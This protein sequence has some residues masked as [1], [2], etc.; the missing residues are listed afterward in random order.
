MRWIEKGPRPGCLTALARQA[1]R[2]ERETGTPPTANDWDPGTCAQTIRD[3]LHS[4]QH[5]LCGYCTQRILAIGHLD[6]PPPNGNGGMRIEHLLPR[7]P[8]TGDPRRM[9]DWENLLGVCGGRS[10]APGGAVHDHCDRTRG[11]QPLTLD[12][13]RAPHVE[14]VLWF[15]REPPD[16]ED[17]DGLW[18]HGPEDLAVDVATLNLN[19]PVLRGRR[20]TVENEIAL[21][22]RRLSARGRSVRTWL[23]RLL[24]TATTPDAAGLLPPFAPVV[25]QY[26]ERKLRGL[27]R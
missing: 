1:R 20:R 17:G 2:H 15:S 3:A 13:H 19:N 18:L 7:D 21:S 10:G 25:R 23:E 4:N 6:L 8:E 24:V 16:G 5:G 12:P 9:Y 22:L 27:P 26:A 14:T 11:S